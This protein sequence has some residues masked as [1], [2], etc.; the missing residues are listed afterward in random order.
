[1]DHGGSLLRVGGGSRRGNEADAYRA[2]MSAAPTSV[3]ATEAPPL[4]RGQR[5]I[6]LSV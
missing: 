2:R 4:C 1:M 3:D 6:P 5:G